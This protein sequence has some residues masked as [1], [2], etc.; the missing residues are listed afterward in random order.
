MWW[1]TRVKEDLNIRHSKIE[2]LDYLKQELKEHFLPDNL[3]WL[4][5]KD[6]NKLKQYRSLRDYIKEFSSLIL[7]I[8]NISEEDR[9]FKFMSGL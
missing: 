8:N 6:L 4:T 3:S 9:L 7:G 1:R 5:R 2:T